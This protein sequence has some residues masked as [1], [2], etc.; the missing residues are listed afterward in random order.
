MDLSK[1]KRKYREEKKKNYFINFSR[2]TVIIYLVHKLRFEKNFAINLLFKG[3]ITCFSE[4]AQFDKQGVLYFGDHIYS[5]LEEPI[6]KLRWHTAAI[7]PEL[8]REIRS[9]DQTYW[10]VG[11]YISINYHLLSYD[12]SW[13]F[14]PVCMKFYIDN[15]LSSKIY[16]SINSKYWAKCS[17]KRANL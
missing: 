7:V 4:K 11:F 16:C 12:E 2:D 8:A 14:K 1:N 5:D 17:I 9:Q 13:F 3:N 6:L 10:R 15:A